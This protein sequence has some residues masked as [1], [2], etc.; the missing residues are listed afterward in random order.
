M[1]ATILI[2]Y[3]T[4]AGST[5]EVAESI[6]QT[7]RGEGLR[8]DV[9]PAKEARSLE[10]YQ[11]VILGAPLY[12]FLWHKDAHAFLKRHHKA[13]ETL[14]LAIFALGPWNNKPDEL[15]SARDQL[16][17]ELAKYAW[18]RPLD[19]TVFVGRFD[20][21]KLKFPYN[22]IPAMKQMPYQ[23]DRDWDAIGNWAADTAARLMPA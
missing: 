21:S 12:M 20:A 4:H 23:D 5:T 18:L 3:A 16:A 19:T 9:L 17:K 15:Q 13:L 2:A 14:P 11:A 7:L 22:L 1:S 6:A 8:A 10:N